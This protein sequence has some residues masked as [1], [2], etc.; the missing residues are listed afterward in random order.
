MGA[1][2]LLL[3]LVV[4]THTVMAAVPVWGPVL[5]ALGAV[6]T[7]WRLRPT[8]RHRGGR[9]PW[10][11]AVRTRVSSVVRALADTGPDPAEDTRLS[12]EDTCPDVSADTC[13]GVPGHEEKGAS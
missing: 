9:T 6:V 8:G 7:W 13:P 2:G 12:S 10:R 3:V 11:T 4:V 5:I 1:L